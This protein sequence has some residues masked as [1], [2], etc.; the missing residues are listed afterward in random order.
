M[1]DK[2]RAK[3]EDLRSRLIEAAS[4]RIGQ[5]GLKELR[6]RDVTKDA[7]CALGAIYTAFRDLDDLILHVNSETLGR[8]GACLMARMD[9]VEEADEKLEALALGYLA[10]ADQNQGHWAALFDHGLSVADPI[11]DWHLAEHTSLFTLI[12]RPLSELLTDL[13]ERELSLRARSL[14]AAVHGIVS[15]SLQDRFVAV[16]RKDLEPQLSAFVHAT[17]H[18][19]R[20]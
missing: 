6:A 19:M 17:I 2:R 3:R 18:G 9:E 14:F 13:D 5:G 15:I 7:G 4:T 11:P 20:A 12:G 16:P 8:L 1:T 10:F